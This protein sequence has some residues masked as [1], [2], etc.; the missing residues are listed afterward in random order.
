MEVNTE[1][2]IQ[3]G[4]DRI[5]VIVLVSF[6]VFACIIHPVIWYVSFWYVVAD[7]TAVLGNTG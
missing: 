5:H 7:V 1:C 4:L 3:S 6:M 2:F